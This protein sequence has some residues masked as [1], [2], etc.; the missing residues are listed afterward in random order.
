MWVLGVWVVV[1]VVNI[2]AK[3]DDDTA[4]WGHA[5]GLVAGAIL[6]LF[7]RRPGVELFDR[8][9]APEPVRVDR[10]RVEP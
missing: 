10:S 8:A 7:M 5:G 2:V 9:P 6:I 4:W 1:Q 3:T